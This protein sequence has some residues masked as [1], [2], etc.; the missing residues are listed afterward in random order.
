MP[1][2]EFMLTT[3]LVPRIVCPVIAHEIASH[4]EL[5]PEPLEVARSS[6]LL[7][8]PLTNIYPPSSNII[9]LSPNERKLYNL[10]FLK[11]MFIT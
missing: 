1:P 11:C 6:M 3:F 2:S 7:F 8:S 10:T 4:I 5:F 9:S